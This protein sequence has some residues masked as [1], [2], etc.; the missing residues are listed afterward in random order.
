[1]QIVV[2]NG[3]YYGA[4]L[5]VAQDAAIDDAALDLY[6]IEVRHWWG[7]LGMAPVAQA[8]ADRGRRRAV[9]AIRATEFEIRT[10]VPHDVDVDGEIGTST[11]AT[12]RVVP[13]ALEVYA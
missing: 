13:R 11:P 10:R 5:P 6:T 9:E 3:R 7:L 8:R 1:M 2:G 12:F 4:A